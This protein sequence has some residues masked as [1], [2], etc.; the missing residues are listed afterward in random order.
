M[1]PGLLISRKTKLRLARKSK[2][3]PTPYNIN[4]FREFRNIYNKTL[5]ACKK[6]HFQS[7]VFEAGKDSKKMWDVIKEATN[8]VS[9]HDKIESL[10]INNTLISNEQDIANSFNTFF[11]KIGPKTSEKVHYTDK[12]FRDYL[13]PPPLNSFFMQPINENELISAVNEMQQKPSKD[14]NGLSIRFLNEHI[15]EIAPPLTHIFNRSIQK[16]IFPKGMKISK[17]VPIFK[18]V[19]S[20]LDPG[21]YRPVSI[22][23]ARSKIFEKLM[24]KQLLSFLFQNNFFYEN[25]FGFLKGRSTSQALFKILNFITSALNEGKV[26]AA[27]FL[28]VQKVFDSVNHDILCAKLERAGIRGVSLDWFKSY[29]SDRKQKVLIGSTLSESTEDII[30]G[31]IQGSILGVILFLIF[32]NDIYN[33]SRLIHSILFADD[34]SSLYAAANLNLLQ[35]ELNPELKKVC[36]WY[37]ANKMSIHPTKSKFL[38]FRNNK[39]LIPDWFELL[40]DDNEPG[41]FDQ[42]KINKIKLITN[43][44]IDLKDKS[45]KVLGIH[46][47]ENLN[48]EHHIDHIRAKA[49]RAIFGLSRVKKIF[50]EASLRQIY[51]ANI[52]SHFNYCNLL[53]TMIPKKYLS[54]LVYIQKKAIRIVCGA[55]FRAPTTPLFF[56]SKILPLEDLIHFNSLKFMYDFTN[57]FL[58][59]SF[60]NTWIR[61]RE[62]EGYRLRNIDDFVLPRFYFNSLKNHPYFLFPKLWNDTKNDF[63]HSISR[64]LF[65]KK[66]KDFFIHKLDETYNMH[67]NCSLCGANHEYFMN[68]FIFDIEDYL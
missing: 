44:N 67:C 49:N 45:V 1:T 9:N 38:I 39:K 31:V 11:A 15:Y 4:K 42:S 52:H 12:N 22:P 57:G 35:S 41:N 34:I 33:C 24:S 14:I 68:N 6:F 10:K 16:G 3:H 50:S 40:L 19:D 29:L 43:S 5:N 21:N 47:D 18:N 37:R 59:D 54:K 53:F 32:M 27:C 66:M 23:D 64:P 2:K 36:M 28:D 61:N 20:R 48:F 7:K 60:N 26:A 56:R 65:L 13:P 58:P 17:T 8:S 46:L 62:I 51:F 25:Q 55:K 30:I 63:K